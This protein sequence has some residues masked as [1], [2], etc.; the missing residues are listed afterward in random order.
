[1][2]RPPRLDNPGSWHHVMNRGLAHRP[3]FEVR[4]DIRFF[5]SRIAKAFRRGEIE[6]HAW[7]LMTTHFHLLAYSPRGE[8]DVAL[9]RIQHEHTRRFNR[10][11]GR[12]GPLY[13]SRFTSKHVDSFAYR[14]LLV[15]YIDANPVD[16]GMVTDAPLHL[17]GSAAWYART[18]GPV[19]MERSWI[20]GEVRRRAHKDEYDPRDYPLVFGAPIGPGARR[21]IEQRLRHAGKRD[22]PTDDLLARTP[23]HVARWLVERA[24]LADGLSPGV[25]LTDPLETL[26]YVREQRARDPLWTTRP[27]RTTSSGWDLMEAGIVRTLCNSTYVEMSQLTGLSSSMLSGRCR[28]HALALERDPVYAAEAAR[29]ARQVL[30]RTYHLHTERLAPR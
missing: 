12:D 1:M 6:V 17:D 21:L 4:A 26:D 27:S 14:N 23:E 10:R 24:A 5:L 9:R 28:R 16:A 7:C 13:R 20:E 29:I 25:P 15:S 11:R 19:W 30:W 3:I 2:P 22:D 18:R 8:L